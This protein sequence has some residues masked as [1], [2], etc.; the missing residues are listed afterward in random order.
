MPRTLPELPILDSRPPPPSPPRSEREKYGGLYWLGLVGLVIALAWVSWF[1]YSAWSLRDLWSDV[2]ALADPARD[3]GERVNAA[4]RLARNPDATDRQ[5]WDLAFRKDLP[6]L[7][8]YLLAESLTAGAARG[9]PRGFAL[10]VAY[11]EGWPD[12][13]RLLLTRVI[14]LAASNRVRFPAEPLRA[15]AGQADP[16]IRAWANYALAAG[17]DPDAAAREALA[18]E[19]RGDSPASGLARDLVAALDSS[20]DARASR[21]EA[22]TA[23]LRTDHPG[24]SEVWGRWAGRDGQLVPR[25]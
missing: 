6:L 19:S 18:E 24:A 9:D 23:R 2:Y 1:A 10:A 25:P 8:R 17:P 4:Q 20:G 15:L 21:L 22:A 14:G 3:E 12:W 11:S 16:F 7:G 13:L 5:R